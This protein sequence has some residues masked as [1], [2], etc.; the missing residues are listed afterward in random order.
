MKEK[1]ELRYLKRRNF[2]DSKTQSWRLP[3]IFAKEKSEDEQAA[4]SRHFQDALRGE[5]A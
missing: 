4:E 1:F 2:Y 5:E 3:V